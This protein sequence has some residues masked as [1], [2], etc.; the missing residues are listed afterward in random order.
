M[1]WGI[2]VCV[3]IPL[4]EKGIDVLKLANFGLKGKLHGE[5]YTLCSKHSKKYVAKTPSLMGQ[6]KSI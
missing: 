4:K 3:F 5:A 6:N 2:T 1:D